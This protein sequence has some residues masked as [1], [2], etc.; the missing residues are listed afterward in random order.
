MLTKGRGFLLGVEPFGILEHVPRIEIVLH[1]AL[2][3]WL[4]LQKRPQ[5]IVENKISV[6]SLSGAYQVGQLD[7]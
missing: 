5:E 2:M 1:G 3:V 6:I 4:L 7:A